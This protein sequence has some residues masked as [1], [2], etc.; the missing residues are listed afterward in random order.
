V[1][2]N[3]KRTYVGGADGV[4]LHAVEAGTGPLVVLLHGTLQFWYFWR[5]QLPVLAQLFHVVA[6]DTRG[7]NLS[8]RP[9]GVDAYRPERLVEDV[10]AIADQAAVDTFHLVGH[11]FGAVVAWAFAL[12]APERLDRLVIMSGPHPDA[13]QHALEHNAERQ[14][15][16]RYFNRYQREDSRLTQRLRADNFAFLDA[17][18]VDAG[19]AAGWATEE[20]RKRY[21]EAWSQPGAL[22]VVATYYQA[23]G[24]RVADDAGP[25]VGNYLPR[26]AHQRVT[27]PTM[28]LYGDADPHLRPVLY[29]G[30]GE[31]IDDLRLHRLRG[32]G[33]DL[34]LERGDDVNRLLVEFLTAR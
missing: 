4:R 33:H 11:D 26:R 1:N 3:L 31:W 28:V 27:V 21:H 16:S 19:L 8:S 12:T 30:L 10:R 32:A 7:V 25:A 24:L 23:A 9:S 6:P 17:G 29:T 14:H 18:I 20:D 5:R 2:L 15:A 13:L 22:E 34:P